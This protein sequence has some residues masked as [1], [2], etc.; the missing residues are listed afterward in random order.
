MRKDLM[1]APMPILVASVAP[2]G[3]TAIPRVGQRR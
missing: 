2:A 3:T 1:C